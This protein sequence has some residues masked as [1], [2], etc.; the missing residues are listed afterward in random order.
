MRNFYGAGVTNDWCRRDQL[1]T[2]RCSTLFISHIL[3]DFKKKKKFLSF[4]T[5]FKVFRG[6][7]SFFGATDTRFGFLVTSPL[8]FK[9]L[10][11]FYRG[12]C[13][14]HSPRSTS[15]ATRANLLVASVQPV[16]SPHACAEVG[17]DQIRMSNRPDRRRTRLPLC[18]RPGSCA[19]T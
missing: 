9:A 10:F 13:N 15:G 14:V 11:A 19:K 8:G 18:Q 2:T 16:T 7:L 6:H 17:L 4:C 12:E 1:S 3:H 5:Y